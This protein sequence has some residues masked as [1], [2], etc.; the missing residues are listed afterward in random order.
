MFDDHAKDQMSH[1]PI[2]GSE[3]LKSVSEFCTKISGDLHEPR[4]G[5]GCE[6]SCSTDEEI[7]LQ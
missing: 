6:V 3:E 4:D 7:Q 2:L 1:I 5:C